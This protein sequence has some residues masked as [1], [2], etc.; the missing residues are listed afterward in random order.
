MCT[1]YCVMCDVV[2]HRT[3]GQLQP[4]IAEAVSLTCS[5]EALST[6]PVASA[7]SHT[8]YHPLLPY[9]QLVQHYQAE[10]LY[11]LLVQCYHT[12]LHYSGFESHTLFTL[13]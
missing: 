11:A 10:L 9:H 1:V 7:I 13:L 8:H 2:T 5:S 6:E 12:L 3:A 4:P